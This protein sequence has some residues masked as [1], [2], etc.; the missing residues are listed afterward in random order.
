[1]AVIGLSVE[2]PVMI[3]LENAV[4]LLKR[5]YFHEN[6]LPNLCDERG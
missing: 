3:A 1:M 4:L 2:V 5:K 6:N